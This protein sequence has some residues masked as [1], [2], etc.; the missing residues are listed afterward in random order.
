[1]AQMSLKAA[2]NNV[3]LTQEQAAKKLEISVSTLKKWEKGITFPR[4]P[5]IIK[6]CEVYG[7]SYDD[8]FFA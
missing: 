8:I 7:V 1:M 2:R 4:Q 6:I 5:H 3:N